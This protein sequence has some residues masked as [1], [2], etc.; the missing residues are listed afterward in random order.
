MKDINW[1]HRAKVLAIFA[2][3]ILHV[4]SQV[5]ENTSIFG[6][7]NWWMGNLFDAGTR[8][9]VPVFVMV[10][11]YLLLDPSKQ[12]DFRTFYKKRA[13]KILIPTIFWSIFYLIWAFSIG[14]YPLDL[15]WIL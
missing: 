13:N 15:P 9:S 8:W 4:A 5:L 6:T 10:S 3:V 11:G 12:E 7:Y 1:V 2:V 14:K